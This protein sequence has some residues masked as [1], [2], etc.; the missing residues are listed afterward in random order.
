RVNTA[1]LLR[2]WSAEA[3]NSFDFESFNVGDYYGAVDEKAA[4]ETISKVL[5]PNDTASQGKQLRL[6]QQ[7]FFV[8]CALKDMIRI[9]RQTAPDLAGFDKKYAIQLNDT[10]PALAVAELMR[11]LVD[12]HAM[13]WEP[14]WEITRQTLGYTNHT[15]LPE[16][17]ETWPVGLFASVLP[18]HLEIVYEIN[19]R[20]LD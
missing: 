6:E 13:E 9:H 11:I 8:S 12:E 1:N 4:A 7:Y 3:V 19:R 17:L 14:A 15:L 16:A 5:Y 10:H 2:L 20:F 18:R